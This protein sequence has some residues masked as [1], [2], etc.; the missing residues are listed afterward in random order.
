MQILRIFWRNFN[1]LG[2]QVFNE[3]LKEIFGK[4]LKILGKSYANFKNI[5]EKH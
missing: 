1:I 2:K 5:L 4:I 3:L